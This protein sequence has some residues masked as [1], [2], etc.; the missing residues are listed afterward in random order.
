MEVL[1][2]PKNMPFGLVTL[3]VSFEQA[4]VSRQAQAVLPSSLLKFVTYYPL[5]SPS[6]VGE[7][8]GECVRKLKTEPFKLSHYFPPE[9]LASAIPQLTATSDY[10]RFAKPGSSE[11]YELACEVVVQESFEAVLRVSV[12]PDLTVVLQAGL[13]EDEENATRNFRLYLQTLEMLL[14][15]AE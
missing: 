1:C 15:E 14:K 10:S 6:K 8:W 4:G 11:D 2:V 5:D 7:L 13:Y 9:Q 3:H 12:R